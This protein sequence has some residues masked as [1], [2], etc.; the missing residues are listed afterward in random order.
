MF[1]IFIGMNHARFSQGKKRI[2]FFQNCA[3]A[4]VGDVSGSAAHLLY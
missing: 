3:G 4:L 1:R 2:V